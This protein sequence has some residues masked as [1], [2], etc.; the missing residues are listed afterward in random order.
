MSEQRWNEQIA[1]EKRVS[2]MLASI[3]Q[4]NKKF[5]L[6]FFPQSVCMKSF[7]GGLW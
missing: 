1:S 5:G 3:N 2:L 7:C 6:L 4:K